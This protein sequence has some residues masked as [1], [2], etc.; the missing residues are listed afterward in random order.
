[1]CGCEGGDSGVDSG[2]DSVC[3][4]GGDTFSDSGGCDF[5]E[6]MDSFDSA[7]ESSFEMEPPAE[8]VGDVEPPPEDVADEEPPAEDVGDVEPPPEDVTDEEPPAEDVG[9]VEPPPEDVTDE[10]PPTEDVGDVEPPPEDVADEEPPAEDVGDVEPPP[11]DV[12]DEEPP[13]E[14][15]G[16]PLGESPVEG[17][18]DDGGF[19]ASDSEAQQEADAM[20]QQEADAMAQQEADAMAQ[21]EADAMA[22][23][24]AGNSLVV[25][26]DEA[27][28]ELKYLNPDGSEYFNNSDPSQWK[29]QI[30]HNERDEMSLANELSRAEAR[31][32]DSQRYYSPENIE[33][34][35]I[36]QL[37]NFNSAVDGMGDISDPLVSS[38]N[39]D[40]IDANYQLNENTADRVCEVGHIP[41]YSYV[42]DYVGD[43]TGVPGDYPD[44]QTATADISPSSE[45]EASHSSLSDT[46]RA[47]SESSNIGEH[48]MPEVQSIPENETPRSSLSDRLRSLSEGSPDDDSSSEAP[49]SPK[50]TDDP[51]DDPREPNNRVS[52]RWWWAAQG[53]GGR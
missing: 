28:G 15:V 26:Q 38:S 43:A 37:G 1:M 22:Q 51:T 50:P 31:Y 9:D 30:V 16:D 46:L 36:S 17:S 23:Q 53:R 42:D 4:S 25:E 32:E 12:T 52:Q 20:A 18:S 5:S 49:P 2:C 33:Q 21:Q 41:Q 34:G 47:H 3:D 39:I 13:A 14:D 35:S 45:G 19:N 40:A 11:E 29:E 8:D 24:E 7:P 6:P 44:T 48:E 27:T 10:E